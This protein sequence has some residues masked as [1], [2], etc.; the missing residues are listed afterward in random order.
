[1]KKNTRK[2]INKILNQDG[3][4]TIEYILLLSLVAFVAI[5]VW[6]RFSDFMT[7]SFG[8]FNEKLSSSLSTGVCAQKCFFQGYANAKK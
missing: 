6:G 7:N 5:F 3:Q 8:D 2:D 1:M 4:T